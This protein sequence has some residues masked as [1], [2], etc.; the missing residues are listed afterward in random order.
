MNEKEPKE[1]E[2]LAGTEIDMPGG[3][4]IHKTTA[5][6]EDKLQSMGRTPEESIVLCLARSKTPEA[7]AVINLAM[8]ET[9]EAPAVINLA[10]DLKRPKICLTCDDFDQWGACKHYRE[11]IAAD[12][13]CPHH[14][15]NT[16]KSLNPAPPEAKPTLGRV[17]K[18]PRTPER[19]L[20]RRQTGLRETPV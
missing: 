20:T 10:K 12:H 6:P 17:E 9:P 18:Q 16:P 11:I 3:F 7:S 1:V 8:G 15:R 19:P 2:T 14:S 4:K 5:I 13:T